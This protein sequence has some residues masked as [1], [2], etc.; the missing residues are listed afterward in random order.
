MQSKQDVLRFVDDMKCGRLTRRDFHRGLASV[1]LAAI[2]LPLLPRRALA[3]EHPTV[4]TWGGYEVP[5]MHKQYID[6]HGASP[7]FSLWGDEEEAEAKMRAGFHPDVGMPCSYKVKKW[8]D[9]GFLKP[10]DTSRLSH[11]PDVIEV[12][13]T[14]PDTF[15]GDNR[16]MVTAWWGLTSVTFRTDL[17]PEYVPE[18]KHSWGILWDPKYAGKLSMIDSL[19]D[20]VMVAA[21]YSGAKDP[22]NMTPD[23]VEKVRKLMQ[24]QRPLL[25]FYTND[26]TTWEQALASGEIVAAASWNNTPTNLSKQDLPVMFM[27][28]KEGAMTWTCGLV[29]FSFVTPEME[30]LAYDLIDAYLAPS[31]GEYW[32]MEFGMGHSNIKSF[33]KIPAEELTKRGLPPGDIPGYIA[34]GIFQATIQ[35]EPELQAMFD[36]VKAGL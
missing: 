35:N 34:G 32:I 6:K 16:L 33:E 19:I 25:R 31:T 8:N 5:E 18:D 9:L 29:L 24:E 28:P 22:F 30:A 2:T 27:K 1:G 36:E 20:G 14:V 21:I 12:L 13:K 17:A 26:V 4:Y 11:W 3:A 15:I 7:E 23:E 10:I